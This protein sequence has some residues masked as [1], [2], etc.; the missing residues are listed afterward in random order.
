MHQGWYVAALSGWV[1][2]PVAHSS[3]KGS[4]I[5]AQSSVQLRA[6]VRP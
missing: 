3:Q 1:A 2:S 5:S 4:Q 6:V